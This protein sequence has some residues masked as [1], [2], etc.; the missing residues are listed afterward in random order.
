MQNLEP[1]G[2]V[3]L[4]LVHVKATGIATC[5]AVGT[6]IWA[7]G[8]AAPAAGMAGVAEL[9]AAFGAVFG[10]SSST[11]AW[12]SSLRTLSWSSRRLTCAP[13]RSTSS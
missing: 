8:G 12:R 7:A 11:P 1:V 9:F 2:M 6:T 3:V 10:A 13:T 5:G 4:H